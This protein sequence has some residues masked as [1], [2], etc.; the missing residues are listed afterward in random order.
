MTDLKPCPI[1]GSEKVVI[2]ESGNEP[3]WFF[4]HCDGC[5]T[6]GSAD[7]GISVAIEHWNTRPIEDELNARITKL[8]AAHQWISVSKRMPEEGDDVIVWNWDFARVAWRDECNWWVTDKNTIS[9][10]EYWMP[11]PSAPGAK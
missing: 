4:A 3:D 7:L 5:G 10:V 1:C 11:L 9:G 8:E 2:M 6:E